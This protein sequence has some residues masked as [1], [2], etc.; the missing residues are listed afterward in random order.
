MDGKSNEILKEIGAALEREPRINLHRN[1]LRLTLDEGIL[2]MEGEVAEIAAKKLALE[3]AAAVPGVAGIADRL[4]IPPAEAMED[5]EIRD[6]IGDAFIQEP[7]FADYAVRAWI[8]GRLAAIR[9]PPRPPAGDLEVEVADGVVTLNGR[10]G[11][12][13][14]KRLAGVLAWWVPGSRDVV[15]GLEVSPPE[16]DTDDEVIDAVRLVLEKDP[17]VNAA[18]IRVSCRNRIVTLDGAVPY[19][20]ELEM[21]EADSWYVFGVDRVINRLEVSA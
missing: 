19:P 9:E 14:H 12:I 6:H 20:R 17:F 3:L 15:N 2:T 21:A 5:G 11:S 7:A 8:F 18:Q 1:P 13:S 4:R 10:V 16:E